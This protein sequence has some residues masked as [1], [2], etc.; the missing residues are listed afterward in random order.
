MPSITLAVTTPVIQQVN[1]GNQ[2]QQLAIRSAS[3]DLRVL[4]DTANAQNK[5]IIPVCGIFALAVGDNHAVW[6]VHQELGIQADDFS[7]LYSLLALRP[8]VSVTFNW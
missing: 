3:S 2:Y 7:N 6:G 1:Q 5:V 4:L 8:D